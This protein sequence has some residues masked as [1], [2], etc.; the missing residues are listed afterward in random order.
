MYF[1]VK[2]PALVFQVIKSI[3]HL[4][5][6]TFEWRKNARS[7]ADLEKYVTDTNCL[8]LLLSNIFK[9][10]VPLEASCQVRV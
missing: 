7:S 10:F 1:C 5:M 3:A 4:L 6:A 2:E 9:N 8:A